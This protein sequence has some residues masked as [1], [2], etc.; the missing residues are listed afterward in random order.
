MKAPAGQVLN[1][2]VTAKSAERAIAQGFPPDP[3]GKV[4]STVQKLMED[5]ITYVEGLLRTLGPAELNGKGKGLCTQMRPLLTK[6]PFAAGRHPAGDAGGGQR[7]PAPARWRA[8]GVLRREPATPA[9]EAGLPV[10]RR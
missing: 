9:A 4:D 8:V 2:A 7:D 3:E 5:P 6:Y 10:C 1:N